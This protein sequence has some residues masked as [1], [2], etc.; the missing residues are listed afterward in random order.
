MWSKIYLCLTILSGS[1]V[2]SLCSTVPCTQKIYAGFFH[3]TFTCDLKDFNAEDTTDTAIEDSY[4]LETLNIITSPITKLPVTLLSKLLNLKRLIV[5]AKVDHIAE[6]SMEKV[7]SIILSTNEI[8]SIAE[9]AFVGCPALRELDLQ[10]NKISVIPVNIFNGL[11]QLQLIN[12]ADNKIKSL[13]F[14]LFAH[15]SSLEVFWIE[16]NSLEEV[17]LDMFTHLQNL[18]QLDFASNRVK[19][20]RNPT[21]RLSIKP[22]NHFNLQLSFNKLEWIDLRNT[23]IPVILIDGNLLANITLGKQCKE[24]SVANNSIEKIDFGESISSLEV[25]NLGNNLLRSNLGDICKCVKLQTLDLSMNGVEDIGFC[26]TQLDKLRNLHLQRNR[27]TH[28]DFGYFHAKNI[29]E[30]LD[31]SYNLIRDVDEHVLSLLHNL[32]NLYLDGNQIEDIS[33]HLATVLPQLSIIGLSH[34]RFQCNRLLT[35]LRQLK[36]TKNEIHL[37]IEEPKTVNTTNVHGIVC[38]NN[39]SKDFLDSFQ[40]SE[41][42]NATVWHEL[43]KLKHDVEEQS[44]MMW[45]M[46]KSYENLQERIAVNL[47]AIINTPQKSTDDIIDS[48]FLKNMKKLT[49][50]TNSRIDQ[51]EKKINNTNV[52]QLM[53]ELTSQKSHSLYAAIGILSVI[54]VILLITIFVWYN[55]DKS[56][57]RLCLYRKLSFQQSGESLRTFA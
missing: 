16:G 51:L 31:L 20:V 1:I 7:S 36:T 28:I 33:E 32:K 37:S 26:L 9:F 27:I 4:Y 55:S 11:S 35:I 57:M 14:E 34:N 8:E 22:V 45:K 50:L 3:S 46:G 12:L 6:L 53:E 19:V 48:I 42:V 43:L 52:P 5:D 23:D 25:I 39:K 2:L 21:R 40:V 56:W 15:T 54:L 47:S 49:Q 38:F 29:L 30:T 13:P 24:L 10:N 41:Q 44:H 17:N 18:K